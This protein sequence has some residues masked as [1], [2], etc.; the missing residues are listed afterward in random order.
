[1]YWKLEHGV[2]YTSIL[3]TVIMQFFIM[4]NFYSIIRLMTYLL[5]GFS[6]LIF[7]PKMRIKKNT[8]ALFY[9]MIIFTSFIFSL[10]LYFMSG[11][12]Y[13]NSIV[14]VTMPFVIF[15]IGYS[16]KPDKNNSKKFEFF[17]IIFSFFLGIYIIFNYGSGFEITQTYF[18]GSKN[19]IGP[20]IFGAALL[21][22]INLVNSIQNGKNIHFIVLKLILL[23]FMLAFGLIL[24]N[25]SGFISFLIVVSIF[26]IF[27]VR[28]TIKK[29]II[30]SFILFFSIIIMSAFNILEIIINFISDSLFLN[31]DI[32]NLNSIS[33]GRISGYFEVFEFLKSYPFYGNIFANV[34]IYTPHNY[35][36]NLWYL[37]GLFGFLPLTILY[38][39]IWFIV[40]KGIM[41]RDYSPGIYLMLLSL[42]ISFLEPTYPFGPLSTQSIVWFLFGVYFFNKNNKNKKPRLELKY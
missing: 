15:L 22:L 13:L 24:R 30:A 39:S 32:A 1:M 4:T 23:I 40:I 38:L 27:K 9:L 11:T 16:F 5:F 35:L 19:Q 10:I 18:F 7:L 41:K 42:V 2:V 14:E 8:F 6:F 31:Y 34:I 3:L 17:Y 28:P 37:Y 29:S 20:I 36:L 25:R 33:S 26:L 12:L 21:L